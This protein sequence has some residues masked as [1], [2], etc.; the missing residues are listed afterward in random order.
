[1]KSGQPN[2]YQILSAEANRIHPGMRILFSIAPTTLRT[3]D[4]VALLGSPGGSQ[5]DDLHVDLPHALE[6]APV[7]RVLVE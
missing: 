1:M 3:D 6:R 5:I 7:K 2:S 4:G